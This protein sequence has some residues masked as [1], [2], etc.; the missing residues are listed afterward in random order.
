MI[1]STL[2]KII[3]LH[4]NFAP[5]KYLS[6]QRSSSYIVISHSYHKM[7]RS[8]NSSPIY[9]AASIAASS[10]LK[11]H[12]V[13]SPMIVHEHDRN[14]YAT[15][16][17]VNI[18]VVHTH[19]SHANKHKHKAKAWPRSYQEHR[20]EDDSQRR[21]SAHVAIN[22][23]SVDRW[24]TGPSNETLLVSCANNDSAWAFSSDATGYT[25]DV[26]RDQKAVVKNNQNADTDYAGSWD[27]DDD[28]Y[29]F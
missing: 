8:F 4:S 26:M 21:V 19:S 10:E 23:Y 16:S 3:L 6:K 1:Q 14:S 11:P 15:P 24:L 25:N 12:G 20:A 17:S 9:I 28:W 22:S 18:H 7:Q 2:S 13:T 5:L 27:C 29:V